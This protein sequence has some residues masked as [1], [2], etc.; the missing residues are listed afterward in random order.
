MRR[1]QRVVIILIFVGVIA[2]TYGVEF[3]SKYTVPIIMYHNAEPSE[4]KGALN[5][6]SNKNFEYQMAFLK[7]HKFNV[8]SLTD[9]ARAIREKRFLPHNS[10]VITF[11]DGYAD[12][13]HHAF[14]ILKK[15]G[16]PATIFIVASLIGHENY[17]TWDQIKE[18]E[19]SGI[20]FGSHT[21]THPYLP[22]LTR[23]QQRKEIIGSKEF[24]ESRLGH[25]IHHFSYPIGGFNEDSKALAEE[26]GYLSA[27]TTN[28]G[29]TRFNED[30]Y[31]LKRIRFGNKDN[32][33]W[34]VFV[35]LFGYYNLFRKPV[36]PY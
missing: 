16:F 12:N 7:R 13:Y 33:Y 26:A 29:Y 25:T 8:I 22:D 20:D 18:M 14:P 15:Y 9:L 21:L 30:L 17:L 11:D 19:F 28:R 6:V 10:V 32:V 3:Y 5:S 34:N 27:C 2:A 36:N 35:K 4:R 31:E 24:I 1:F 23:D